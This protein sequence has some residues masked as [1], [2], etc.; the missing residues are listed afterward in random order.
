M[1]VTS[2]S[3]P[4]DRRV[5]IPARRFVRS[6]PDPAVAVDAE[7]RVVEVSAAF[8]R[9]FGHPVGS[10]PGRRLRTLA[11]PDEAGTVDR[12][13]AQARRSPT[14]L[15]L[16]HRVRTGDG[17]YLHVESVFDSGQADAE[18]VVISR[19]VTARV[20]VLEDLRDRVDAWEQ[21]FDELHEGIV[22]IDPDGLVVAAN[23]SAATFLAVDRS[24]LGGSLAR[25]QVVVIDQDG[26]P[27]RPERL[28][29]TRAF[30]TGVAQEE[31]VA[32]RRRDGSVVWLFAR[33]IPLRRP[34]EIRP[35]RVAV[36]LEDV[37]SS[38][39]PQP[40]HSPASA[41]ATLTPRERDVLRAL[42]DGLDV[43][44]IAAQLQISLHTTR[45]HIKKIMHKLDARTQLQAVVIGVRAGLI[46]LG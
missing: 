44:A 24:D 28:P 23:A 41:A 20:D 34:G 29:S 16:A 7:G 26:H 14:S 19:D 21:V 17:D 42:A 43:R 45:G 25:A 2:G 37:V 3:S 8:T 36:V 10:L 5:A 18:V 22:V 9:T 1:S 35:S 15:E 40:S 30:A 13:L 6:C 39:V 11:H 27:M 33:A 4:H 12:V 38:P 32:Y 46:E 31:P